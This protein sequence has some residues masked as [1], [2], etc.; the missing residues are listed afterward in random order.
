MIIKIYTNDSY[1]LCEDMNSQPIPFANILKHCDGDY[2]KSYQLYKK[3]GKDWEQVGTIRVTDLLMLEQKINPI[4]YS[5]KKL[6]KNYTWGD[7]CAAVKKRL[8]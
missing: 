8:G 2:T 4:F 6:R 7:F 5:L 1:H 3:F